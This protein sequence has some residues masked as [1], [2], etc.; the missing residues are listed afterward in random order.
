M[1]GTLFCIAGK[2]GAPRRSHP[3]NAV[4]IDKPDAENLQLLFIDLGE[5]AR[6]HFLT[7]G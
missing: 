7:L 3:V 2:T 5:N 1:K 4:R 6:Q